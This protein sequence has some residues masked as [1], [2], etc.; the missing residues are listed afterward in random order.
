M[1]RSHD[2]I[3][4]LTVA[5]LRPGLFHSASILQRATVQPHVGCGVRVA[6]RADVGRP[7]RR[8]RAWAVPVA[9]RF[10]YVLLY[11]YIA[12]TRHSISYYV[13]RKFVTPLQ[14]PAPAAPEARGGGSVSAVCQNPSAPRAVGQMSVKCPSNVPSKHVKTR[15]NTSNAQ[16]G[17]PSN[18]TPTRQTRPS[19]RALRRTPRFGHTTTCRPSPPLR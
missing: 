2:L 17:P 11:T 1:P 8:G 13:T 19:L 18:P 16:L 5:R 6:A 12:H 10:A 7:P 14:A 15:Q 3:P 9:T 4:R